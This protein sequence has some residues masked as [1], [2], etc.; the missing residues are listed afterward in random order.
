L[1]LLFRLNTLLESRTSAKVNF[2]LFAEYEY[3]LLKDE[4]KEI[5]TKN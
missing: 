3:I 1:S 4:S 2:K 5:E